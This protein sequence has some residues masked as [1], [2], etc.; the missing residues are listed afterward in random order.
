MNQPYRS[1][2]FGCS[3][4]R[5]AAA[6]SNLRSRPVFVVP[7]GVKAASPAELHVLWPDWP[8]SKAAASPPGA[9]PRFILVG[10]T[11]SSQEVAYST[12]FATART[13]PAISIFDK[14][15]PTKAP[16]STCESSFLFHIRDP[17]YCMSDGSIPDDAGQMASQ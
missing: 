6:V 16:P 4:S 5:P 7:G 2:H 15:K 8:P 14:G 9:G 17:S 12:K 11:E 10:L 3:F 1:C 13:E